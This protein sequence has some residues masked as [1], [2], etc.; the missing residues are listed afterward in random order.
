MNALESLESARAE[1]AAAGGA[2]EEAIREEERTRDAMAEAGKAYG[3]APS[4]AASKRYF[5]AEAAF[6]LSTIRTE[7]A[8][9]RLDRATEAV[10]QA[11]L[12]HARE[13]LERESPIARRVHLFEVIE[14][15]VSAL[16]GTLAENKPIDA[17]LEGV[18]LDLALEEQAKKVRTREHALREIRARLTE[19]VSAIEAVRQ[20]SAALGQPVPTL[21]PV[22]EKQVIAMAELDARESAGGAIDHVF[23]TKCLVS[24]L[25][26]AGPM[27]MAQVGALASRLGIQGGDIGWVRLA[28]IHGDVADGMQAHL[29]G[30]ETE[31]ERAY[32]A[33]QRARGAK[34]QEELGALLFPVPP[35]VS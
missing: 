4:D 29:H 21:F 1:L 3:D 15:A 7:A 18:A 2:R 27:E 30:T 24:G 13:T 12:E 22:E 34:Q 5:S 11:E 23:A 10:R 25:G 6:R 28:L 17:K 35:P 16:A 9:R 33:S 26:L 14:A 19:H 8:G 20:A 32:R 31:E